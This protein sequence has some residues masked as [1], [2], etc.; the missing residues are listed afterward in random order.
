MPSPMVPPR[1]PDEQGRQLP[2]Y[3]CPRCDR[4][5]AARF[6]GFRVAHLRHVGWQLFMPA[7][8]VNWRG[9]GQEVIPIPRTGWLG[10]DAGSG[11]RLSPTLSVHQ[12]VQRN[13]AC[14][15]P[16]LQFRFVKELLGI[17]EA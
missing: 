4:E 7:T 11:S 13:A 8:Y 2:T 12:L 3:P 9:N 15:P 6:R 16:A 5:V 1:W 17:S 10:R 14:P